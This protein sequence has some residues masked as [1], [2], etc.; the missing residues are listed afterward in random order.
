MRY[1]E[2]QAY[3]FLEALELMDLSRAMEASLEMEDKEESPDQIIPYFDIDINEEEEEEKKVSEEWST[4]DNHV[5]LPRFHSFS[6][7]TPS[8]STAHSTSWF[9]IKNDFT[10]LSSIIYIIY[11]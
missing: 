5:P 3:P 7:L 4:E 9:S 1:E 8:S 6:G 2:E 11:W 10:L